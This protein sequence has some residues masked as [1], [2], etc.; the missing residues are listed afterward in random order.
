MNQW[1]THRKGAITPVTVDR[2]PE[3]S[4]NGNNMSGDNCGHSGDRLSQNGEKQ[5]V[6]TA[7]MRVYTFMA[8]KLW[9]RNHYVAYVFVVCVKKNNEELFFNAFPFEN[10]FYFISG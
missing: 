8:W 5:Q 9:F 4:R 6:K 2:S 3:T 7:T 10:L 1:A